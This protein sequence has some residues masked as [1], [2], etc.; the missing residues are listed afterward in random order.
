MARSLPE[1]LLCIL[2]HRVGPPPS[3]PAERSQYEF[4]DFIIDRIF[5]DKV[6]RELFSK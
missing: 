2:G 6:L 3:R 5:L 4:M 1:I